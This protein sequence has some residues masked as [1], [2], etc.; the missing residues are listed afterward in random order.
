M[1]LRHACTAPTLSAA[2]GAAPPRPRAGATRGAAPRPGWGGGRMEMERSGRCPRCNTPTTAG[3]RYCP[4]CGLRL[5]APDA[6]ASP[7][8]AGDPFLARVRAALLNEY[9]VARE[10]GRGGMAAVFLAQDLR[11]PRR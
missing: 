3:L 7:G 11:L 4:T 10:I 1:R 9:D 2:A 8:P 5:G 6:P